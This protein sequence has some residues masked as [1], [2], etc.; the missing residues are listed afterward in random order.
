MIFNYNKVY[1]RIVFFFSNYFLNWPAQEKRATLN[2]VLGAA[3][4]FTDS[5]VHVLWQ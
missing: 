5:I 1:H 3:L 4:F 2:Y